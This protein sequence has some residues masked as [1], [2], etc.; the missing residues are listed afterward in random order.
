MTGITGYTGA[1]NSG[2]GMVRVG[3]EKT[4]GGMAVS[5]F[6]AGVRMRT[7]RYFIDRRRHSGS[8]D[9]IVAAATYPRDTRVIELAVGAEF[10]E[11]DGVVTV[12]AFGLGRRVARRLADRCYAVVAFAAAAKHFL[13]VGKRDNREPLRRVAGLAGIAG[14]DM[15]CRLAAKRRVDIVMAIHAIGRQTGMIERTGHA[16][17]RN[18]NDNRGNRTL[19]GNAFGADDEL[20]HVDTRNVR[21]EI[22]R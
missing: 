12:V 18:G 13:V 17:R 22:W 15:V 16:L 21:N 2:T 19:T 7:W 6:T 5:A 4:H 10:E 11:S 8:D 3:I 1:D 20:H 14:S 9:A